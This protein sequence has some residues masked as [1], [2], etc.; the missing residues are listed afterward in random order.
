MSGATALGGLGA[1][2]VLGGLA[3]SGGSELAWHQRIHRIGQLNFNE[4]DP[5]ELDVEAWADY[6][7]SLKVDAVLVSVTGI[8]AFYPTDVPFHRRSQFLGNKDLYG[9]C[10]AAA[11]R[12]GLRVIA[13]MSPDLN[14]EDAVKAHPEWFMRDASGGFLPHGEDPR[15]FRTCTFSSYFTEHMPAIMREVQGRYDVDGL[16]TNAWPPLDGLPVCYCES[17]R[18]LAKPKS[19]EYWQQFT[20]RVATLW[21]LYDGIAKEKKPD[22]LF[23]ANMGGGIR[24]T[25]NLMQLGRVA[26]WYNCDNQGRGGE[27]N[28]VWGASQQGRVATA[29]MKSR[30]ITNVTGAWSTCGPVR[31]RNVSKSRPEAE[32]W[33]GQSAA[34]GMSIWYHW[35]GAQGGLG[36]DRRWQKIGQ[37]YLDW[38]AHHDLHFERIRSVANIGVVMGQRSHLFYAPPGEG[39]MPQFIDGLYYA[40]LEGRFFFDFVHEDDLGPETVGRYAALVLPNIAWLSD[41]QCQQLRDYV[42]AG[43]SLMASFETA[44]FDENGLRRANSGLADVFGIDSVG[45]VA[46]PK[47]N[48]FYARIEGNHPVVTGF[49]DT[50]WIPGGAYRLPFMS[51]SPMVLSVVAAHTA[52]PP[53]LSY[54]PADRTSEPAAVARESGKSRLLYLSGDVERAAWR[55]G[56][57]DL[58]LLLQNALGWVA[59]GNAPVSVEGEGV[60]ECFAWETAAGFAVHILNY[61]NP[62][63]HRGW[64]RKHYPIGEQKVRMTV[65]P[66]RSVVRVELLRAEKAIS[67]RQDGA[68]VSFTIPGIADYEVA[69]LYA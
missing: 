34:S 48:G 4:R 51:A 17:C 67:F 25:P 30:T 22:N 46:G 18:G 14:W 61:T 23:F 28:P 38:M 6:W 13:R 41:R 19:V 56:Q 35:V 45:D 44:M 7:V 59:G 63:L 47:G 29:I 5:V 31:W 58:S 12:R 21:K 62:N 66:G 49:G 50:A 3:E 36:Q 15:L 60:V 24:A 26:E 37:R 64:L 68:V 2:S 33:M 52:Y 55:S 57:T 32:I 11:K 69:A 39:G 10:T 42:A 20:D 8:L 53:E 43:G 9:L 40:L 16:F 65:P 1:K 27:G 54:A